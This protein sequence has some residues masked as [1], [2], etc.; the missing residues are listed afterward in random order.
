MTRVILATFFLVFTSNAI[1]QDLSVT[2]TFVDGQTASA[3]EVNQN[4]TDV[5]TYVNAIVSKDT[6]SNTA[7]GDNALGNKT[8]GNN[9]IAI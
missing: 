5:V 3:A 1:S 8:T 7:T 9:N 6:Q 2:N 4:F